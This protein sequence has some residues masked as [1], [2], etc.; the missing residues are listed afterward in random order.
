MGEAKYMYDSYKNLVIVLSR[1][2]RFWW[3]KN[4]KTGKCFHISKTALKEIDEADHR[5]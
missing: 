3:V 4:V 1:R 5:E 2:N